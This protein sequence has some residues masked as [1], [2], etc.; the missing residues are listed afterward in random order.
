VR[1]G[2]RRFFEVYLSTPL[3]ECERRD[4]KGLYARAR[5][6]ELTNFT[7]VD[8]PY[9]VPESPDLVIDTT[10]VPVTESVSRIIRLISKAPDR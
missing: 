3:Q 6:G 4:A 10:D 5:R 8:D 7:G 9:E 2:C 1:R